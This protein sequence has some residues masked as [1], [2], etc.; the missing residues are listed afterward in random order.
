MKG[1]RIETCS[2]LKTRQFFILKKNLSLVQ[3]QEW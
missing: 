3:H 1:N 2:F